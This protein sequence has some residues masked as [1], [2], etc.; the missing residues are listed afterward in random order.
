[1]MVPTTLA[2]QYLEKLAVI[3]LASPRRSTFFK[4]VPTLAEQGAVVDCDAWIGVVGPP[5]MPAAVADTIHRAVQRV[6]AE[7]G[8][9]QRLRDS[10]MEPHVASRAEF[11]K[12][13]TNEYRRWGDVVRSAKIVVEE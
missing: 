3:G 11:G 13:L 4:N 8:L 12:Y 7:P 9:Q 5:K 6:V 2:G 10:G 1:M